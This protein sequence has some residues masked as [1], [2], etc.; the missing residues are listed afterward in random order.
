MTFFSETDWLPIWNLEVADLVYPRVWEPLDQ[1]HVVEPPVLDI[2]E[3]L[4]QRILPASTDW[5]A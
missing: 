2:A 5:S 3:R 4:K 1:A